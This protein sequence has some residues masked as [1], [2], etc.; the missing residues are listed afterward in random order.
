M[1]KLSIRVSAQYGLGQ[2]LS[3]V[4]QSVYVVAYLAVAQYYTHTATLVGF[5]LTEDADTC[6]ILLQSLI[7]VVV[8]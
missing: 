6:A 2:T 7:E 4:A 8:Q 5:G 3:F 1:F